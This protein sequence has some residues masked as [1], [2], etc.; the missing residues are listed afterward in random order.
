MKLHILSDLHLEFT[1]KAPYSE[2]L[3]DI[4]ADVIVLACDIGLKHHGAAWAARE[5]ARLGKP[6]IY[7]CGNHEFY[8]HRGGLTNTSKISQAAA[9]EGKVHFLERSETKI[10]DVRFLGATLWTDFELLGTE[11]LSDATSSANNEM[12]DYQLI[13]YATRPRRIRLTAQHTKAVHHETRRSLEK[14]LAEP[15]AGATVVITHHAPLPNSVA[16][17]LADPKNLLT[18]V[19][20]SN[21]EDLLESG[22][23]TLWIH[24]HTHHAWD[25]VH[26]GTRVVCNARGYPHQAAPTG[27]RADFAV[28]V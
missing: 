21:L 23:L 25:Y 8:R 1:G 18:P 5:S 27:F 15:C 3:P 6:V 28:E 26:K 16:H 12:N 9:S 17:K 2:N 20:A 24:G 11:R 19:Y 22:R 10:G 7:V 14:R 4:G 13:S